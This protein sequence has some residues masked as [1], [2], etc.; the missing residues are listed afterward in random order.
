M[1]KLFLVFTAI[2]F[3]SASAVASALASEVDTKKSAITW[4]ATKITGSGHT[5][6]IFPKSSSVKLEAG[7]IVSGEIIFDMNS[8]TVTDIS[9]KKAESFINHMKSSDFFDVAKH[10]TATLK[11]AELKD[12]QAKGELIIKGKSQPISFKVRNEGGKYI[13]KTAFDRTK[14]GIIYRSG[15]F[16]KKLGDKTI[17]DL[18]DVEFTIVLKAN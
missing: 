1:K 6:Q 16:F 18:V 7:V 13:G 14:Y 17:K 15:N 2:L 5:G 8:I 4:T 9:G 3:L 11:V 12:G 10:P